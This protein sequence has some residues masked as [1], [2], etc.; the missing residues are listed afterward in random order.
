VGSFIIRDGRRPA[1]PDIAGVPLDESACSTPALSVN[2]LVGGANA[3]C[4]GPVESVD[5]SSPGVAV[6]ATDGEGAC[7]GLTEI[8][9]GMMGGSSLLAS[10]AAALVAAED[11]PDEAITKAGPLDLS[12][13]STLNF[14]ASF[15]ESVR[16]AL[17]VNSGSGG[18]ASS[19][20]FCG[21]LSFRSCSKD[22]IERPA[23]TEMKGR[24]AHERIQR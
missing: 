11:P 16:E 5:F 7:A 21:I 1:S 6:A 10:S 9:N 14:P 17:D 3:T 24:R 8:I 2:P 22:Q 13:A 18:A 4:T 15:C 19:V 23:V 12:R 20:I